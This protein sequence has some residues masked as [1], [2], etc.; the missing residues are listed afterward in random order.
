MMQIGKV[1]DNFSI[2]KHLA[3]KS[4]FSDDYS[5]VWLLVVTLEKCFPQGAGANVL[6][7]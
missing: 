1:I 5:L 6:L 3:V 7:F 2:Y 4:D